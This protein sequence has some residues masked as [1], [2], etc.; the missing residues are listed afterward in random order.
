[1]SNILLLVSLLVGLVEANPE[2]TFILPGGAEIE[3]MWIEPGTFVMGSDEV[4]GSVHVWG[5]QPDSRPPHQVTLTRGFWMGKYELT[6]GQWRSI[7][8]AE[9]PGEEIHPWDGMWD[10]SPREL[11][12]DYP[13]YTGWNSTDIIIAKLNFI[14]GDTRWRLPT[15]AEWEYTCRAGTTTKWF[16]G[17]DPELY[18]HYAWFYSWR[19]YP[20]GVLHPVGQKLPNPWGLHDMY[21]NVGEWCQD[22]YAPYPAEPQIDPLQRVPTLVRWE[23]AGC[24]FEKRCKTRICRGIQ[25]VDRSNLWRVHSAL[26][27]SNEGHGGNATGLRL[28]RTASGSPLSVPPGTWGQIKGAHSGP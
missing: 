5:E 9:T 23:S 1:M 19:E 26:R 20:E 3:M 24:I 12:L 15:E 10:P 8:R 27:Y 7:Y 18:E 4:P 11:G 25:S 16:F 28:V 2:E 13:F 14:E 22:Y 6:I 21:G 17:D